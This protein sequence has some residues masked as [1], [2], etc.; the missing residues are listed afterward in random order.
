M[1]HMKSKSL[2]LTITVSLLICFVTGT[3]FV[4][5]GKADSVAPSIYSVTEIMATS[6]QTI[7]D[8]W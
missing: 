4:E 3:L 1:V 8:Y 6:L 5:F 2:A 7:Q